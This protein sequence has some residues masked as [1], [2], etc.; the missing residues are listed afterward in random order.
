[1]IDGGCAF[2]GHRIMSEADIYLAAELLR[3]EILRL[4]IEGTR[5]FY[6]GGAKG[7]DLTASVVALNLRNQLPDIRLTVALPCADHMKYWPVGLRGQYTSIMSRADEV[8][9]VYD[10]DYFNGCMQIRNRYMCDRSAT[11]I[12]WYRGGGGG[13]AN[14][15]AYAKSIGLNVVNL[16]DLKRVDAR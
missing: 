13:T 8:K 15:M 16:Y 10:G 6:A 14:T 2:T 5:N 11:L 1:M 12:A 4:Y 9:Y 7:F 3:H